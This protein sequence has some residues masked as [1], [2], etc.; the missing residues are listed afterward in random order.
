[1]VIINEG[2]LVLAQSIGGTPADGAALSITIDGDAQ[3][4]IARLNALGIDDARLRD[5]MTGLP[6]IVIRAPSDKVYDAVRD[7]AVEL[8]VP[9][10][11]M[12]GRTRSLEDLY[13]QA[14]GAEALDIEM[15][16][17]V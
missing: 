4:F 5:R 16:G 6:E 14:V 9:L 11:S 1:V 3:A 7:T 15:Y 8:D 17:G 10:I 13:L 2:Q 12:T